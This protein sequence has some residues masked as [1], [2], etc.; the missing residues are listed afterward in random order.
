MRVLAVD[1][2]QSGIRLAHSDGGPATEVQGVSRQ[3][4]DVVAAVAD[5]VARGWRDGRFSTPDRVVLGL[6]TAPSDPEALDR[7]GG[8]VAAATGADEVWITDD[9]VTAHAGALSMGWG[10]SLVA[11]TGVACLA[12]PRAGAPRI[13]GGHGFLLG[14][15]GGGFWIGSRG[16]GAVLR[17][18]DGRGPRTGLRAPAEAAF[19]PVTG[20]HVRVHE[21]DRPV[22]TIAQFAPDV[23]AAAA[24]GDP[25]ASAITNDAAGELTGVITAGVAAVDG[26]TAREVVPLALGGRLLA[27]GTELRRRL[28]GVLASARLPVAVRDADRSALEGA[29]MLGLSAEHRY[30]PLVHRWRR[31]SS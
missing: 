15:E 1:G 14:D 10:V 27:T 3:E 7:L 28:D 31:D 21:A 4:G 22:N 16:L 17:A 24:D 12:L 23:L 20:L 26:E 30:G 2:G 5:A 9:A 18:V 8:L 29:L 19:G 13:I 25:V 11:G 6:T